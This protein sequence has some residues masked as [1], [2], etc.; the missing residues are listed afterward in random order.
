MKIVKRS[1]L[2]LVA[3]ITLLGVSGCMTQPTAKE[4]KANE[5]AML[6]YLNKKYGIEFTSVEYIPAKRGFND[7]LNENALVTRSD[8]D[9]GILVNAKEEVDYK[10]DYYDDYLNSFAS[11]MI[12][13]KIDYSKIENKQF[14]KTYV[15]LLPDKVNIGDLKSGNTPI[16]NDKVINLFCLISVSSKA[17][18]QELKELYEVYRQVQSIGFKSNNFIVAF[19]GDPKKDEKY[20]N[21]YFLYGSKA[22]ENYDKSVKEILRVSKNGLSF[23]QFKDQLKVVG[24]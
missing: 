12:N 22:W 2:L 10:G 7:G 14:A 9:G 8:S 17:N 18:D 1:A 11:K 6:S 23:E 4:N 3:M 5:K 21:N 20:V 13:Q 16:T 24:G 15:T 19:S